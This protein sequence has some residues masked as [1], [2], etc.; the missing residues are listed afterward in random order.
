[1][2][3]RLNVDFFVQGI[4]TQFWPAPDS[5]PK[6]LFSPT[7]RALRVFKIQAVDFFNSTGPDL[8]PT[9][10]RIFARERKR[11]RPFFSFEFGPMD[12]F[13]FEKPFFQKPDFFLSI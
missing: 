2:E 6:F 4:R 12:F 8:W 13:V 7:E 5:S 10:D 1:M 11:V 3:N 9:T